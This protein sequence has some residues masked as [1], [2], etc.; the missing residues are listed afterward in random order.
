MI[1]FTMRP[2]LP[3]ITD[4][5]M[6]QGP[7]FCELCLNASMTTEQL[8]LDYVNLTHARNGVLGRGAVNLA[9]NTKV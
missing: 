8:L 9:K 2:P 5:G 3:Y 6:L 4:N 7:V 1:F